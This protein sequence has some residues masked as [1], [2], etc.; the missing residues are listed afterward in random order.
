MSAEGARSGNSVIAAAA[1][2]GA[3]VILA[4]Q[5]FVPPIVGLADNGD[6]ER[7]MGYAGFQ[8]T[9]SGYG[10]RYFSFLRRHY[11]IAA[12]AWSRS[13]HHSSET[14]LALLARSL[15]V[16]FS[17][18][19]LFDIRLLGGIHAIL[20]LLALWGILRACRELAL[21]TRA[22]LAAALV[23][24]FTDVGYAAPFNSF[25]A[26]TASL[27]FLLSTLAIAAEA[28]RRGR[29]SGVLLFVYFAC[30]LLFV[31]SKPQ[32]RLTAPLLAIFGIR[33]AHV[34]LRDVLRRT[35]VWLG[36]ALCAFSVWYGRHTPFSLRELT[37][38][39][40]VFDDLLVNSPRPEADAEELGLDPN[41]VRYAGASPYGP[42]S[43]LADPE[44]RRMFLR[45]V[46][47]RRIVRFYLT[48]PDRL[49]ARIDR[50]SR[51]TWSLRPPGYG[52]FESSSGRP[53]KTLATRFSAW[54]RMRGRLG[55]HPLAAIA[56][57]LGGNFAAVAATYRRSTQRGRLF[58]EG[59]LLLVLM[60]SLAFAVCALAQAPPDLS[61][62][63][64]AYHA[65][66]DLLVIADAGWIA[67]RL[68]RRIRRAH[69]L[70]RV[71]GGEA[72]GPSASAASPDGSRSPSFCSAEWNSGSRSRSSAE[73]SR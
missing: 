72:T 12:I 49:A 46:G 43:P 42:R 53:P 32:E 2:T 38:F 29:L 9:P 51:D 7:V 47:H 50:A 15:H 27:L 61:R 23:F 8:H 24:V 64:Y 1:L 41:W 4:V 39:Q 19:P 14:A 31:G 68:V 52:N 58:R 55:A 30:A 65:E 60:A 33:L 6:Y 17:R 57:L 5:L 45:R 70:A 44:F 25:Y 40:V 56:L 35:A 37:M 18:S 69:S 21:P 26:Q 66:I 20:L 62:A 67:E 13:G 16:A 34:R 36:V 73:S 54:S 10:E 71:G 11:A 28:V 22:L 3:A 59:V 63:L 48:H